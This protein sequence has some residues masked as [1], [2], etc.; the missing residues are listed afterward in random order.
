MTQ[1]NHIICIIVYKLSELDRDTWVY[2]QRK[3]IDLK[4]EYVFTL[5]KTRSRWYLQQT[6][7][8]ADY[9]DDLALLANT[10]TQVESL[11]QSLEQA[12]GCIGHHV[13]ADKT[14]DMSFNKTWDIFTLN[15]VSLKLVDK[16]NYLGSSVSSSENDI[17]KRLGK[18]WTVIDRFSI[19][20]KSNLSNKIKHIFSNQWSCQL[21]YTDTSLGRW[22]SVLRK[23]YSGIA[24][25]CYDSYWTNARSNTPKSSISI[26]T[27]LPSL[28]SSK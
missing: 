14:E 4:K 21:Y 7:T 20:W 1:S 18:A 19:I 3:S 8:D 27:Y 13:N 28:K 11:L 6:I 2:V 9:A 24:Q 23:S 16:A 25:E 26:A 17:N 10:P 15:G 5:I 12:A 22:Q